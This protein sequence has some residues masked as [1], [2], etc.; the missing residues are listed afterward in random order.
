MAKIIRF[1]KVDGYQT[2]A[3]ITQS[4]IFKN[5]C[6]K[7]AKILGLDVVTLNTKR[8]ASKFKRGTGI[9]FNTAI[10]K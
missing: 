6:E 9:V 2:R 7:A 3:G 1:V 4:N 5:S 10:N 8:Q